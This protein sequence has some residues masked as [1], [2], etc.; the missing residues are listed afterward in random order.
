MY[1]I[2]N[3]NIVTKYFVELNIL[4]NL[5]DIWEFLKNFESFKL[6]KYFSNSFLNSYYSSL[7][8]YPFKINSNIL[9]NLTSL[10]IKKVSSKLFNIENYFLDR[11]YITFSNKSMFVKI[12]YF[13]ISK[14]NELIEKSRVL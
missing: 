8:V 10:S 14:I 13:F 3:S 2:T 6:V 11:S 1:L 7:I 5:L 4:S 12:L 9:K